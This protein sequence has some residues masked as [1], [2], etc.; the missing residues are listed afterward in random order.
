MLAP[1]QRAL[2]M[3]YQEIRA[4][5]ADLAGA[6]SRSGKRLG[7]EEYSSGF[8]E[9]LAAQLRASPEVLKQ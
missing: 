1:L 9:K 7:E 5:R 6:R 8:A 2:N 4:E 3:E